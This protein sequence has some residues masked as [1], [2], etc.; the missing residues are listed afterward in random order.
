[1]TITQL[2]SGIALMLDEEFGF[3]VYKERVEQDLDGPC[4]LV[5]SYRNQNAKRLLWRYRHDVSMEVVYFPPQTAIDGER[6]E[7][8]DMDNVSDRLM[9]LFHIITV[10]D[11][12][13]IG[14]NRSSTVSDGALVMTFNVTIY[15]KEVKKTEKMQTETMEIAIMNTET[16]KGDLSDGTYIDNGDDRW[17]TKKKP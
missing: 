1:M 14:T 3:P 15:E 9:Y 17:L 16:Y 8:E 6:D 4:F 11:E 5:R 13:V 12:K 7:K 10:G 2:V